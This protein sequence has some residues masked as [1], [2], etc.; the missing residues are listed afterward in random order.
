MISGTL[1]LTDRNESYSFIIKKRFLRILCALI[2]FTGVLYAETLYRDNDKFTMHTF[3]KYVIGGPNDLGGGAYWYLYCYLGLLLFL[4]FL[5]RITNGITK[6]DFFLL[7]ILHFILASLLPMLNIVLNINQI[8]TID[9]SGDFVNSVVFANL[10][11]LFY[12]IIGFYIDRKVIINKVGKKH[13]GLLAILTFLGI[14]ASSACT[15]YEGTHGEMKFTQNYVQLFDYLTTIF[16]FLF[17]KWFVIKGFNDNCPER[18]KRL[19]ITI[20]SLTFAI[21]L[22]DPVLKRLLYKRFDALLETR[23]PTL[24]IS[25]AWCFASMILGSILTLLLKR[26]PGIKNIL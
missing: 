19:I 8:S 22:F 7:I 4:P 18:L 9:I 13:M 14:M 11:V 12:P 17:I 15:F 6:Q 25:I 2:I 16:T 3:V 24:G 23:M 10:K 1:L 21:Y 26:I 5:R 20:G